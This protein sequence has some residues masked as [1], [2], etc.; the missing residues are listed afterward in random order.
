MLTLAPEPDGARW[1]RLRWVFSG[2]A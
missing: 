1:L 2:T